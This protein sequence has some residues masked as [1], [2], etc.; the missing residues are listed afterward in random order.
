MLNLYFTAL[1][2]ANLQNQ[3]WLSIM[4]KKKINN[5]RDKESQVSIYMNDFFKGALFVALFTLDI[6][7]ASILLPAAMFNAYLVLSSLT[8]ATL[9]YSQVLISFFQA[10]YR[11]FASMKSMFTYHFFL[12]FLFHWVLYVVFGIFGKKTFSFIFTG[13]QVMDMPYL[14]LYIVT[15]LCLSLVHVLKIYNKKHLFMGV[16]KLF[17]PRKVLS[18]TQKKHFAEKNIAVLIPTYMPNQMTLDLIKSINTWHPQAQIVVIDDSTPMTVDASCRLSEINWL[19]H[20]NENIHLLRT[21][22]NTLKAGALNNG[23]DYLRSLTVKPDVVF[24]FDDDVVINKDTIPN[25]V[26]TLYATEKTGAVCSQVRIT[27]KNKNILTRLQALEY[28]SFNITKIADNGFMKGPLVMQGML[29]AFRLPVLEQVGGFSTGHLIEDYE[30]TVRLKLKG[31]E[32]KIAQ[33]AVAWTTVPESI[34]GLWKQRA[35]W[36]SGGLNVLLR[37]WKTAPVIYQDVIGHLSFLSLLALIVL[38]FKY[39]SSYHETAVLSPILVATSFGMFI[40]MLIYNIT[41]LLEYKDRDITDWVLKFTVIPEFIYSNFLSFILL[42]SYLF[43]LYNVVSDAL[44]SAITLLQ[45][46]G[47]FAFGKVGYSAAWGTR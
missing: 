47:L 34:E 8:K 19:A 33:S 20:Q 5:Y 45:K 24:T 27:N 1:S 2:K 28:H 43:M 25:M 9:I 35:R 31:W 39:A 40:L 10:N 46:I 11:R 21:P 42:G 30:I 29:T 26:N 7:L 37:Y 22:T 4:S 32:V 41:V 44:I 18:G 13:Q 6:L 3:S 15:L 12:S 23:I 14:S 36:T 17:V 16:S 38:S